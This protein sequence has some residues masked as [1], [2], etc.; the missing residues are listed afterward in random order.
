M[1]PGMQISP[2]QQ[3][4]FRSSSLINEIYSQ[5]AIEVGGC[6][7]LQHQSEMQCQRRMQSQDAVPGESLNHPNRGILPVGPNT[8]ARARDTA[9]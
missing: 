1:H 4:Q 7:H 6:D 2:C 8:K 3:Q 5:I 9:L